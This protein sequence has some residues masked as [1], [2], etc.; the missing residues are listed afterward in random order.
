VNLDFSQGF[1]HQLAARE[2][3]ATHV[4]LWDG[5]GFHPADGAPQVPAN[6]RLIALPSYSPELNPVEK[7]WDQL[8]DRLC[9]QPFRSLR[10]LQAV[11]TDFLRTFWQDAQRVV[12]LIGDGWLLTQSQRFFHRHSTAMSS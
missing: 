3:E 5:A 11:M 4:V 6:V 9:N 1:L 10:Q 12:S 7:L 8:K 2:P